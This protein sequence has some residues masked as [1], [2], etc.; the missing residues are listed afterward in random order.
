MGSPDQEPRVLIDE[1][2]GEIEIFDEA[3]YQL[4]RDI[5]EVPNKYRAA[6]EQLLHSSDEERQSQ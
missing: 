4:C 1:E 3:Y 2:T 5:S 6:V